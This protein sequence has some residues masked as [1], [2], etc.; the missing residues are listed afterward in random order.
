MPM[1]LH[2]L[3]NVDCT[4]EEGREWCDLIIPSTKR[5]LRDI[6][7]KLIQLSLRDSSKFVSNSWIEVKYIDIV[8]YKQ[9]PN[10][11]TLLVV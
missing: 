1:H 11:V 10:K 3:E 6:K 8:K 2:W 4:G 5:K 7:L 9:G